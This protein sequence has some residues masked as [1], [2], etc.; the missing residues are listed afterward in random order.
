MSNEVYSNQQVAELLGINKDSLRVF[1]SRN[2]EVLLEGTH[3][4]TQD[5]QTLWTQFGVEQLRT[6]QNTVKTRVSDV[7]TPDDDVTDTPV[8]PSVTSE[9]VDPLQRYSSLINAVA[10]AITPRL[11]QRIDN[12]VTGRV[13]TAIAKPMTATE[14]VTLLT[15]LGLK[16]CNPEL[17]LSGNQPNLLTES[18]E[19]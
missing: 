19:N 3:W 13:K 9:T 14:C 4:F 11:L 8:T 7:E 17:L 10:D 18:K 1:K 15:E 6:L 2:K 16:P 5:N 12:A